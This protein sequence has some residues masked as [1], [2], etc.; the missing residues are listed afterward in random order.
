M[1]NNQGLIQVYT[2][3]GKGKTTA[4]VG[5]AV[6]ATG[7]GRRVVFAQ[8][9]KSGVTGELAPL[10]TLGVVVVRGTRRLGFTF[11]MD[12]A[13]RAIAAEEQ[14]DILRR[15]LDAVKETGATLLILDE[16][17]DALGHGFL[18]EDAVRGA[19]E[20][21][22]AETEVVLTGRPVPAWLAE[23][24]DYISDIRKVKHP[25]TRGV[26]ARVGIEN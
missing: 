14:R 7:R 17:L 2:G 25:F 18:G 19:L 5:L 22:H 11:Q 15:A 12:D 4:A 24:A 10:E 9:L 21:R 6:R 8:F 16:V 3:N 23:M 20:E 26:G 1:A 13:T